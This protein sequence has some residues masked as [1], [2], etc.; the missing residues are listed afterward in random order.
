MAIPLLT[1]LEES[2]LDLGGGQTVA[3]DVHNVVD[4]ATDPV[5]SVVV[6]TGTISSELLWSASGVSH[7]MGSEA[8]VVTL[9][10]VQIGVH[11]P[12]VGTPD[13]AGHTGPG[14][15]ESQNT[16]DI[17]TLNLFTGDRVNDSGLNA[18]ERQ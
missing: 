15:L 11:V 4:T 14:F 10:Y 18:E 16:L 13:S 2:G 12:F 8:Y 1:V 9:V 7:R 17:V 5:I 6:T 3:G